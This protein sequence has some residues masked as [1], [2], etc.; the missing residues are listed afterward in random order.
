[1]L[2]HVGRFGREAALQEYAAGD[3]RIERPTEIV[4][5][6]V[7][8]GAEVLELEGAPDHRG[9]LHDGSPERQPVEP[10]HQRVPERV[11]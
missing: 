5:L 3:D 9:R 7:D 8:Q 1:M 2:E 4:G 11:R 6:G 10:L